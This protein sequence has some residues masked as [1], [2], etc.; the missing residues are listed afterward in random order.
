M[1]RI[2]ETLC[3]HNLTTVILRGRAWYTPGMLVGGQE[4]SQEMGRGGWGILGG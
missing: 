4:D 3:G 1:R 2:W